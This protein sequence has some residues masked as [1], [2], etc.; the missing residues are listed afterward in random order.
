M[1]S[2][3]RNKG[4]GYEREVCKN[5]YIIFPMACRN[6]EQVRTSEGRDLDNTQPLCIQCKRR[7]KVTMA[8]AKQGLDEAISSADDEYWCPMVVFRDD[9]GESYVMLK[10][11]DFTALYFDMTNWEV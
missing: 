2:R 11:R 10:E 3:E 4:A 7:K 8:T 5:L 6:L 1:G 9:A